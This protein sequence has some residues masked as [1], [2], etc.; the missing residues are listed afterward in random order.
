MKVKICG[1][2]NL[3]DAKRAIKEGAD[4]LGI[5]L[6]PYAKRY[7]EFAKAFALIQKLKENSVHIVGIFVEKDF[8]IIAKKAKEL[9]LEWIQTVAPFQKAKLNPLNSFKKFLVIP[10]NKDGSYVPLSYSLDN[11]DQWLYDCRSF[12]EGKA[13]D[14]KKFERKE[15]GPFF[16]AGGLNPQNVQEAINIL[17]PQ[18]V[19]VSTGVCDFTGIK[20]DSALIK[21][22]IENT[23]R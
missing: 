6:A 4:Y 14:W 20:K 8:E 18:G 12:G 11:E 9:N 16:L 13:F 19:D 10:V 22:F 15:E 3:E 17:N 21:R 7:V 5:I 2:T 23:K 1:I